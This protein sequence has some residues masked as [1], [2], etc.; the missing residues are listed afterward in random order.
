MCSKTIHSKDESD[1]VQQQMDSNLITKQTYYNFQFFHFV[2]CCDVRFGNE[3]DLWAPKNIWLCSRSRWA[4]TVCCVVNDELWQFAIQLFCF[5]HWKDICSFRCYK[6]RFWLLVLLWFASWTLPKAFLW[7]H[8]RGRIAHN[9]KVKSEKWGLFRWK[10]NVDYVHMFVACET[11]HLTRCVCVCSEN[12][13]GSM[14]I[15]CFVWLQHRRFIFILC[16]VNTLICV[17]L[18]T[19]SLAFRFFCTK[20]EKEA[21]TLTTSECLNKLNC[22]TTESHHF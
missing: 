4:H 10:G 17:H 7:P 16:R 15:H 13:F 21:K 3:N 11:L 18:N 1:K 20:L 5:F 14:V 22:W 8:R 19:L 6:I 2:R 12:M 9:D